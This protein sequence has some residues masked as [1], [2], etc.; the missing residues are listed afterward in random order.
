MGIKKD[1]INE[2]RDDAVLVG[3][4]CDIPP[5]ILL[6]QSALETGWGRYH[7]GN[8]LFGIKDVPWI[9][10]YIEKETQEV[11]DTVWKTE[12]HRFQTFKSPLESMIAYVVKIRTESRY[13]TA[14]TY[15]HDPIMYFHELQ[16]A[17]YATDPDYA[18][19]L[20]RIYQTFPEWE[21]NR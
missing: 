9:P 11:Y 14:W 10:G 5:V 17:G 4:A 16:I 13:K 7:V 8:N 3:M 20:V 15:R 1:F 6:V 21:A 12:T 18:N 2:H 19:K